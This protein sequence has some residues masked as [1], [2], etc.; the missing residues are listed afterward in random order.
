M[1]RWLRE[2]QPANLREPQPACLGKPRLREP[3][4]REPQPT[5]P[6]LHLEKQQTVFKLKIG[7]SLRHSKAAA[8]KGY[9]REPQAALFR[10]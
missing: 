7:S 4:L 5:A 3:R 8:I 6:S 2:P 1:I 9:L 10:F